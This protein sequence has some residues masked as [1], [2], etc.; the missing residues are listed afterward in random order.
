[1]IIPTIYDVVGDFNY[2]LAPVKRDGKYG[3]VSLKGKE[4][5]E[6]QFDEAGGFYEGLARV[7][8]DGLWGYIDKNG[9][10][11]VPVEFSK[12]EARI[13]MREFREQA[14]KKRPR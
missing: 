5:I 2:G 11:V 4:V 7:R 3:Y 14:N 1:M 13:K 10:E 6:P 8:K 9:K 12:K